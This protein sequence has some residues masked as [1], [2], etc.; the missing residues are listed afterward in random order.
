[1]KHVVLKNGRIYTAEQMKTA[2]RLKHLN[3]G[4]NE[5]LESI[6]DRIHLDGTDPEELIEVVETARLATWERQQL[7]RG[8][9]GF[10]NADPLL[11]IAVFLFDLYHRV[12]MHRPKN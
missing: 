4:S 5:S 11:N 3:P 6:L 2:L 8:L 9:E 12:R 7:N 10:G 1:M